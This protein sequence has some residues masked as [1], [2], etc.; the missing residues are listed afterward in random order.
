MSM[1]ALI[2]TFW[3][4]QTAVF[5]FLRSIS[6]YLLFYLVIV[7]FVAFLLYGMDKRFAKQKK[8]RIPEA[9]LIGIALL[10]GAAGAYLGMKIFRHKTQHN[11]FTVTIP[12]L[13][14]AQ[15]LFALACFLL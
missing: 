9:N 11:R 14:W 13:L 3:S 7:N 6:P 15:I 2:L 10:Y 1:K 8:W 4:F 5:A 12:L